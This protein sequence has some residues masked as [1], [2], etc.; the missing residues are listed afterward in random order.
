MEQVV[1]IEPL[2]GLTSQKVDQVH[3]CVERVLL[4]AGVSKATCYAATTVVEELCTNIME[5]SGAHWLEVNLYSQA[6]NTRIAIRDDG[7]PFDPCEAIRQQTQSFDLGQVVDRRLGLYM[8]R[9]LTKSFHCSRDAQGCNLVEFE[10]KR[11]LEDEAGADA[12]SEPV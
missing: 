4:D 12:A 6:G 7:K 10:V 1:R 8:V 3:V 9:R 11:S 2:G 5:H